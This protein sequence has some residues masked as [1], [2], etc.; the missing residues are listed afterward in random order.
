[1][2]ARLTASAAKADTMSK[3]WLIAKREFLLNIRRPGFL[4]GTFAMPI[5]LG[6]VM[7][8]IA[9]FSIQSE[10][11]TSRIGTSGYVDLAG[12]LDAGID[13]PDDFIRMADVDEA[14][15]ALEAGEI[16]AYFV[17]NPQYVQN[18]SIS[19]V[20]ATSVP[21]ALL[22]TFDSYLLANLGSEVDPQLMERLR[23]PVAM[24]VRTLDNNR[25]ITQD[26]VFG[27]FIAPILFV[28]I[29]I[30]G[31]QST[32]SYLMSGIV[33]EKSNRLMEILTTSV[34]PFQLMFGKILGLGALGLT[35][36]V[37]W[38]SGAAIAINLTGNASFMSGVSLPPDLL[39]IGLVYFVLTYFLLASVMAGIGAIFGTEQESRQIAG[40]MTLPLA[41][42]FFVIFE[43][44]T[45]PDGPL[46]TALTLIPFT[47]PVSV[48][49]RMG[50]G[51]VPAWQLGISLVLLLIT[52]LALTWA[53]ARV[54]RYT[55]LMYGKRPGPRE[56]LRVL[57]RGGMNTTATGDAKG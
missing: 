37:I 28:I 34:T 5:L 35:M 29:F 55:L 12:V 52:T 50:F 7:V 49:M 24:N 22:D 17:V 10:E 43:F 56:L 6:V 13:E 2:A 15:A 47:S 38:V 36:L 33:E 3:T 42:P 31:S 51:S 26:G 23:D 9:S 46:V 45:N 21:D 44:F 19:V 16:G 4:F 25:T 1:M 53:S 48:I 32:S 20:G 30:I 27:L 54:F 40:L 18:G 39:I 57:R 14:R 11:D 8:V 41:I